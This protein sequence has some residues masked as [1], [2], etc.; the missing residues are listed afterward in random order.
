MPEFQEV[1]SIDTEW[2]FRDRL[3]DH[4]SAWEPVVFCAVGLRSGQRVS[5][6]GRDHRLRDFIAEHVQDLFVAH[7]A[8]AEMKYLLRLGIP[9]LLHWFDTFVAWRCL[10]NTPGKLEA[11][12]SVALQQLGLP[13]L[14]PAA[15][16]ALREKIVNLRFDANNP[17][18]RREIVD[19]CFSDCNGCLALYRRIAGRVQPATVSHWMEY[20]KAVARMELRGLPIDIETYDAIDHHQAEIRAALTGGVND[21]WPV[22]KG[23]SFDRLAFFRWCNHVGIEWPAKRSPTT[24]KH[25]CS[26]DDE[27]FKDMEPR[28]SFIRENSGRS[29]RP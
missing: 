10:M 22:F 24:G 3:L 4:E 11:G 23:D 1:W 21:T 12:L 6:W 5:F 14:A 13:H 8:V 27:T 2:G 16:D 17:A 25:Y 18:E 26:L 29:A 7:Y 9:L 19:Y 20:L 28:H 15:K